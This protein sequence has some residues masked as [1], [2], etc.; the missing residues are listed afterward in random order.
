MHD[1]RRRRRGRFFGVRQL[2]GLLAATACLSLVVVFAGTGA[3]ASKAQPMNTYP[4]TVSGQAQDG[5][6]LKGDR[7]H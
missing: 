2:L 4:P 1:F 7:G 5:K 6:S 3:A